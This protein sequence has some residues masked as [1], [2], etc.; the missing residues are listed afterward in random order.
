LFPR[1][2]GTVERPDGIQSVV[3]LYI[4][5]SAELIPD[6]ELNTL[7]RRVMRS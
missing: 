4:S 3:E 6:D 7:F 5:E 1:I 2:K